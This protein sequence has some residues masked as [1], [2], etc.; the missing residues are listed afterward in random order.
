MAGNFRRFSSIARSLTRKSS[1]ACCNDQG[2]CDFA[3]HVSECVLRSARYVEDIAHPV[4]LPTVK[5]S[6]DTEP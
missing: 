3:G 5:K 1:I 6:G 2:R 4:C